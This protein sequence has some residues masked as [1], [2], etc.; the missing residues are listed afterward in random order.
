VETALEVYG[1]PMQIV[2]SV[3]GS[4]P[5][6]IFK[7]FLDFPIVSAGVGYPGMQ[8]H[9]PNENVRLDLYLK[10]AKHI[11]RIIEAFSSEKYLG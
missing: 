7:E 10:G 6:S 5:N 1:K 8:A 2:P 11:V 3:G 4:G 9:A